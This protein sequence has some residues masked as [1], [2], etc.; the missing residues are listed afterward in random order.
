MSKVTAVPPEILREAL[1]R[2]AFARLRT[3][4]NGLAAA[5]VLCG[6]LELELPEWVMKKLGLER[7]AE[8]D[9]SGTE[10]KRQK[11]Q[12]RE[13]EIFIKNLLRYWC[14]RFGSTTERYTRYKAKMESAFHEIEGCWFAPKDSSGLSKSYYRFRQMFGGHGLSGYVAHRVVTAYK[15]RLP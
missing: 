15:S 14:V 7:L 2:A 10:R 13:Q 11:K 8:I 3:H 12:R 6:V 5:L 4:E 9:P 1:L